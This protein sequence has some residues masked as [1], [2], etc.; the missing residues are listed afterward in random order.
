MS[1][2]KE[3]NEA[4]EAAPP[5]QIPK[6]A[7]DQQKAPPPPDPRD[8]RHGHTFD[9]TPKTWTGKIVSLDAWRQLSEWEK[10]GP[11]GRHWNGLTRRWEVPE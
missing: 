1:I 11:D 10:H 8:F 3:A 4:K 2:L 6:N 5:A 9:G 7:P